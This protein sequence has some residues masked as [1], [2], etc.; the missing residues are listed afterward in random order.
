MA[1][2]GKLVKQLEEIGDVVHEAE[3][4]ILMQNITTLRQQIYLIA[5]AVDKI[6][7]TEETRV[8]TSEWLERKE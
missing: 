3:S 4:E 7:E 6:I 8:R 2:K 1:K 5:E